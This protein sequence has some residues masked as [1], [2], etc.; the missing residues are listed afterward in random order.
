MKGI[1][2]K[3]IKIQPGLYALFYIQL[4]AEAEHYGYNL[5]LNGSMDRDLD[6]V[7]VPWCDNPKDEQDMIKEFQKYLTG[8]V[9]LTPEGKIHY[10]ILPG[11]RHSYI[12]NLNRGDRHGEWQRFEDEEFYIDISVVQL[13]K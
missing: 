1:N 12:I 13:S 2:N 6:L 8:I 11:N 7:A 5:L 10:T 4:K 3:P 9:T